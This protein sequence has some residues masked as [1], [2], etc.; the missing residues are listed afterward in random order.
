M[1]PCYLRKPY[2]SV[3]S[4]SYNHKLHLCV[5]I[6]IKCQFVSVQSQIIFIC[7]NRVV[8]LI[9]VRRD[10]LQCVSTSVY[11]IYSINSNLNVYKNKN[12]RIKNLI[13]HLR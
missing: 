5:K 4:C 9:R 13:I 1:N 6:N 12:A 3:N 8:E 11:K 2:Y 7:V 10:A